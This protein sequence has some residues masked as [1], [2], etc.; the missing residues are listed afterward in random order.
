MPKRKEVTDGYSVVFEW[1]AKGFALQREGAAGRAFFRK[2]RDAVEFKRALAEE[3]M[4]TRVV[5][6]RVTLQEL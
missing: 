2:R 4:T 1:G 3:K 5:K 6:A